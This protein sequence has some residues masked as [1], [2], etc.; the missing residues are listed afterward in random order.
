MIATIKPHWKQHL[1]YEKLKDDTT[2]TLLFGGGAGGGKTWLGCEWLL[3][4]CMLYPETR[5]YMARVELKRLREST[6]ITFQKVCKHHHIKPGQ[7]FTYNGQD[8]FYDFH[9]SSRIDCLDLRYLP[10]DPLYERYG[11]LE[12]TGGFIEEGSEVN[13]AAYDTLNSRVGRHKNDYYGIIP[14]T[15][16]TAVPK[17][18]WLYHT[19]YKPFKEGTLDPTLAFIQSLVGDNPY[20]ESGY[21]E[22]LHGIK[23]RTL[24]E[25]LLYGNWEYEDDPSTLITYDKLGDLFTNEH[26]REYVDEPRTIPEPFSHITADIARFGKDK[27]V[28]YLWRSWVVERII[29]IDEGTITETADIIRGLATDNSIPMSHVLV[30]EAGVGGGV[31][32]ILVCKGFTAGSQAFKIQGQKENYGNLRA[33]CFFKFAEKVNQNKVWIAANK[34]TDTNTRIIEELEVVRNRHIEKDETKLMI[35]EKD[36]MKDLLGGRSP[37]YAD[38]LMM[39][40]W[41]DLAPKILGWG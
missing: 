28:I 25:R 16:I 11:S 8:H 7:E 31:K 20:G 35:I 10:S 12:Y 3:T 21:A 37:D 18:N 24:K 6:G 38:A 29:K 15:L 17:K 36:K 14:K 39:R 30:D 26:V 40:I 5:F 41:F 1:A 33:Q 23:D 27:T 4:N 13:F 34:D 9:N 19:F 2:K 32:D 22:N